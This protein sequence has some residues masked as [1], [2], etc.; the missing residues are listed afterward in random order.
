[1]ALMEIRLVLQFSSDAD[2]D[3]KCVYGQRWRVV[4]YTSSIIIIFR[5]DDYI[6]SIIFYLIK[7]HQSKFSYPLIFGG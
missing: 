6:H 5:P 7:I 4:K 2:K 1:M 3:K